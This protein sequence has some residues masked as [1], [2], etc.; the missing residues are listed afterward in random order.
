[1]AKHSHVHNQPWPHIH[2]NSFS[3]HDLSPT[4]NMHTVCICSF[5]QPY[6]RHQAQ[7]MCQV[8]HYSGCSAGKTILLVMLDL[9]SPSLYMQLRIKMALSMPPN[10]GRYDI[11]EVYRQLE[12]WTR[13]SISFEFPLQLVR[14]GRLYRY[15]RSCFILSCT[16]YLHLSLPTTTSETLVPTFLAFFTFFWPSYIRIFIVRIP[17][18]LG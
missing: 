1:M 11:S 12:Y 13:L 18:S 8:P 7:R 14:L 3:H 10:S 6:S 9:L 5:S 2:Y 4:K 15:M 16:C 17:T